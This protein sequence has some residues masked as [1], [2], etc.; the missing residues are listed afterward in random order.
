MAITKKIKV[1]VR[2]WN[3]YTLLGECKMVQLQW[4]T[5]WWFLKMLNTELPYDSAIPLLDIYPIELKTYS[6]AKNCA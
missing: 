3:P 2:S 1:S 6:L 5:I 4:K